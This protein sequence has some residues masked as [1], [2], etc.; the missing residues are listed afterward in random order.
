MPATE[1]EQA[2]PAARSREWEGRGDGE[3]AAMPGLELVHVWTEPPARRRRC[4][5]KHQVQVYAAAIT[6]SAGG[7]PCRRARTAILAGDSLR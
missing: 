3:I 7:A 1:S 2:L 5:D 4:V 6:P